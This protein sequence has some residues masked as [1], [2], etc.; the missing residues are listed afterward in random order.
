MDGK[1]SAIEAPTTTY[2]V[3]V[4]DVGPAYWLADS[5]NDPIL[6]IQPTKIDKVVYYLEVIPHRDG[7]VTYFESEEARDDAWVEDSRDEDSPTGMI[8]SCP[9]PRITEAYMRRL[10][11]RRSLAFHDAVSRLTL[12]SP[13]APIGAGLSADAKP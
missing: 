12:A 10:S 4:P 2:V 13:L 7:C 1:I 11:Q 5:V 9:P 6:P 3:A 8:E